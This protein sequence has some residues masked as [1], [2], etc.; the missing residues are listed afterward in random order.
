MNKHVTER[1][2]AA[3]VVANPR[4]VLTRMQVEGLAYK[5][6]Q[7]KSEIAQLTPAPKT[8][9]LAELDALFAGIPPLGEEEAVLW[10]ADLAALRRDT[11]LPESPWDF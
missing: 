9:T 3:E 7:G 11:P 4:D 8:L 5:I 2:T 6:M 10:E 1:I